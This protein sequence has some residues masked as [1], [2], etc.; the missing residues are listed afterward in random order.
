MGKEHRAAITTTEGP[1]CIEPPPLCDLPD[2]S[3]L[4]ASLPICPVPDAGV[5]AEVEGFNLD[6]IDDA[7]VRAEAAAEAEWIALFNQQERFD[8]IARAEACPDGEARSGV[9]GTCV[10]ERA[11]AAHDAS[12]RAYAPFIE[13]RGLGWPFSDVGG[14][15]KACLDRGRVYEGSRGCSTGWVDPR[16]DGP[17]ISSRPPG[18]ERTKPRDLAADGRNAATLGGAIRWIL[19]GTGVTDP[20]KTYGEVADEAAATATLERLALM[21]PRFSADRGTHTAPVR[22]VVDPRAGRRGSGR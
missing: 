1:T 22:P 16:Y 8:A 10:D 15:A 4:L 20:N 11:L 18:P 14:R 21:P 13:R 9:S 19:H 12:A 2:N 17:R 6:E 7:E 5:A 3:A